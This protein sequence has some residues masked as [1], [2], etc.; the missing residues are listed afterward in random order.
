MARPVDPNAQYTIK[1]HTTKGYTY[2][3]TQPPYTDPK[4]G[5][6]KYRYIHWGSVDENLKFIPGKPFILATSEERAR[7]IFP[8]D[9]DM[10]ETEA[11]MV[12][13][14]SENENRLYGDV[15]L[16]E[17]VA[18]AVGIRQDL[19]VVFD[20][21]HEV[22]NDILTLAMFPYLTKFTYNRV[23]RWQRIA[24]TPSE[25]EL[26]PSK[27]TRFTQS[28]TEQH[29]MALL[30]LRAA[31]L[32]KDELCA[33]DSTSRP[34]YG[35]ILADIRWGRN[36]KDRLP[37]EQTLE[38][39]VY[40]L[41][42]HMPVYYRTFPGNMPDSRSI[43]IILKDLEEAG[44]E[45][46][47]LVTDRG[48]DTLYNLEK[49]ISRGQSMVMCVKVGQKIV[50]NMIDS[51]KEFDTRP[52]E[53]TVDPEA[54]LYHKQYDIDYQV[55]SVGQSAKDSDKLKLNL[56]F[57]PIR[58]GQELMTLDITLS[59]QETAL[60]EIQK[61]GDA[62]GNDALI[63][64]EYNYYKVAYDTKTRKIK[65]FELNE[66]KVAKAVRLSGF[67]SL[68]THG[69]DFDAMTT[70]H[71]YGL[72][73]EQEKYFQQ[74]KDQMGADSQRNWSED[75]KTGR[76]FILFISLILGSY[77]RHVWKSSELKGMFSSSLEV[78]DEMRSI[79]LVEYTNQDKV[80]TPFVGKQVAICKAFGFEIPE[81]CAPASAAQQKPKR[82]RGRPQKNKSGE[83]NNL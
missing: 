16:I 49:Y 19:E 79:R 11:L 7:L 13:M 15:W 17:Q 83:T 58:R 40:T 51:F 82:K 78:L 72:R 44:F 73:D 48:Y 5:K 4:T 63:K 33:V 22:V 43:D 34:A 57:D 62:L 28:I 54:R 38:V 36:N 20:G 6:K 25:N 53:M 21:N 64:R 35:G 1:P 46:L 60:T 41:S 42:S 56:Y 70:L 37:L 65:S 74:M 50:A 71:T 31:R 12:G 3:S 75:G 61:S 69:T 55:E 45:D 76:L 29:R 8:E 81:G 68:M 18:D 27:I 77:V 26:T 14:K 23:A 10:S 2:A 9:W 59:F 52:K 80:I 66:K 32:E 30:Q 67:F 39:V 24:K 47:V